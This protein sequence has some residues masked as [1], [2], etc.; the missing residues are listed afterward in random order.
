MEELGGGWLEEAGTWELGI[1][2]CWLSTLIRHAG[3]WPLAMRRRPG[4]QG[5]AEVAMAEESDSKTGFT[6]GAQSGLG[7]GGL[8]RGV[9]NLFLCSQTTFIPF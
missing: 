4:F 9:L 1:L 2:S 5:E 7:L 3:R 8:R 6:S